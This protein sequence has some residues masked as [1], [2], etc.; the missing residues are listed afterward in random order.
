MLESIGPVSGQERG[1]ARRRRWR[2]VRGISRV[3]RERGATGDDEP[4]LRSRP[5]PAPIDSSIDVVGLVPADN[6]QEHPDA[7]VEALEHDRPKKREQAEAGDLEQQLVFFFFFFCGVFTWLSYVLLTMAPAI[8]EQTPVIMLTGDSVPQHLEIAFEEAA[9][10]HG[11]RV[12]SAAFGGCPV[13]GERPTNI[14]ERLVPAGSSCPDK[15]RAFQDEMIGSTNPD[16]VVWWDRWSL[17]PFVKGDGNV[18]SP[19]TKEFW[20]VRSRRLDAAVARLGR[21]GAKVMFIGTEPPGL[22]MA[23][24]CLDRC[25]GWHRFLL[26]H[27]QDYTKRWNR[28]LAAFARDEPGR[29]VFRSVTKHICRRD[30]APCDDTIDGVAARPDGTHYEGPG[31]DLVIDLLIGYIDP[32]LTIATPTGAPS[33]AD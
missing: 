26:A 22:E 21:G 19:G 27:Y 5:T 7:E 28:V 15:V 31:E 9:L 24:T 25:P 17:S 23:E 1:L 4:D 18:V 2:H 3:V 13:T 16:V 33:Q 30:V 32:Y 11:W 14:K 10:D 29:A 12:V 8:E 20:S 6:G